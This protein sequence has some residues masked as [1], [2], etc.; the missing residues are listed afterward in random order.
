MHFLLQNRQKH[1]IIKINNEILSK[2]YKGDR[3]IMSENKAGKE[4]SEK[5]FLKRKKLYDDFTEED[6]AAARDYAE[7]YMCFLDASKTE[8][9]AVRYGIEMAE[10]EGYREFRFGESLAVGG[11]YYYNN[12]GKALYIFEIG[13][14][15][16]EEGIHILAAHIDS[17]RLDLKQNPLYEQNDIAY[18]KTHYYGGV[19][20]YQWT[21]I[22]LALHGAVTK[23]DG[24]TIDITIGEDE[25]E[26]VFYISDLL[27]HLAKDQVSR[28]LG[29]AIPGESLN[30]FAGCTPLNLEGA[31][32]KIK[33]NVL[34]ILNEKYGITEADFLSAELS[35]VPA[36]RA[37]YVG[38]DR[39]LI[40]GYGHDDRVCAY[41]EMTGFFSVK[42]HERTTMV[43]LADKEETG[44]D[45]VTGMQ[46][47]AFTDLIDEICDQ[48]GANRAA[49]RAAS[50]CL[51]ADVSAAFDPH[52]AEVYE[53][54]N[55]AYLNRGVV[56]NK[57]TG[58][59]GKSGTSDASAEFV[60][61][62]RK[63]FDEAGVVWQTAELGKVDQGGG[64]TVAAYIAR[65]NIDTVDVG[66]PVLSMHAPWEGIAVGDLYMTHLAFSAFSKA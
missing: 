8:R 63:C 45:G 57:Y 66:V 28:P 37:R 11:K 60:G 17:P 41:T 44:S 33:L 19:K 25:S 46:S 51:S 56:L 50:R 48:I 31:E 30:L 21:T 42:K 36:A 43:I 5:L 16:L 23:A 38:L 29:E 1:G 61:W 7:G 14:R 65:K 15:A 26:P 54:R 4:L 6:I 9:E 12:R 39:G 53:S 22:P 20:K 47:Q 49:V 58:A 13:E 27:P 2:Y 24:T 32:E 40:G 55:S 34:N 35:A 64:G 52:F 3:N 10:A 62:V 18:L 59:R